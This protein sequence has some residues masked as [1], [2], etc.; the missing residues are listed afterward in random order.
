MYIAF[1]WLI[2]LTI[3]MWLAM[4]YIELAFP[5]RS[6]AIN[7]GQSPQ[8]LYLPT[9]LRSLIIITKLILLFQVFMI[10]H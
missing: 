7:Q 9:I 5:R 1:K 10:Y 3:A 4:C 8:I 6:R 2:S